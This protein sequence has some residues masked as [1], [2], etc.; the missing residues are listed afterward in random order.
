MHSRCRCECFESYILAARVTLP[1]GVQD[2][3]SQLGQIDNHRAG[4]QSPLALDRLALPF[5]A[6]V[7]EAC[8]LRLVHRRFTS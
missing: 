7:P 6:A 3:R 5:P 2:D 8:G 4:S 1:P